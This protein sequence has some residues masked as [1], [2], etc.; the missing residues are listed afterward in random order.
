MLGPC[1]GCPDKNT[2]IM[3]AY[4]LGSMSGPL[5][6]A[7]SHIHNFPVP[8]IWNG[9]YLGSLESVARDAGDEQALKW[10]STI[11]LLPEVMARVQNSR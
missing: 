9:P 5:V 4:Y 6:V 10:A 2:L 1:C 7:N 8:L 3:T 11:R